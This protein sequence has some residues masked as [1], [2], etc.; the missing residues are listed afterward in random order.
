MEDLLLIFIIK[1]RSLSGNECN[2]FNM[3]TEKISQF[4][5][6][7]RG[8][9]AKELCVGTKEHSLKVITVSIGSQR[10]AY[11]SAS[12]NDILSLIIRKLH[13]KR[14]WSQFGLYSSKNKKET[15]KAEELSHIKEIEKHA[16]HM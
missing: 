7:R 9:Q 5:L 2:T 14:Q 16:N 11:I 1:E 10:P 8:M 6:H 12:W 3:S 4:F 15:L 13:I